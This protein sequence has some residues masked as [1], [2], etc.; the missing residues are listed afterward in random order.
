[1]RGAG[2]KSGQPG[3]WEDAQG[4]AVDLMVAPHQSNRASPKARAAHLAPH[5]ND[6]AR[7]GPGLA[8]ALSDNSPPAHHRPRPIRYPPMRG[9]GRRSSSSARCQDHQDR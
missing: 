3:H 7:I 1:M 8:A 5:A 9:S 2:F 4:I 6:V